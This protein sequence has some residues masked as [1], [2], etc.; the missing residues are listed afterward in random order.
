MTC[1]GPCC[2]CVCLFEKTKTG[3]GKS[4]GFQ[5]MVRLTAWKLQG[6]RVFIHREVVQF[7]LALGIDGQ[8]AERWNLAPWTQKCNMLYNTLYKT[9]FFSLITRS[10]GMGFMSYCSFQTKSGTFWHYWFYFVMWKFYKKGSSHQPLI[11][12]IND[13]RN[14]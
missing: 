10:P 6:A 14:Y 3:R 1:L 12:I 11:L 9:K 2:V 5:H 4:V 7:K 8:P 13:T